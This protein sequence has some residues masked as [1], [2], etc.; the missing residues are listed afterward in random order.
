MKGK[1]RSGGDDA[2]TFLVFGDQSFDPPEQ[3][4]QVWWFG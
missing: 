3:H 4:I 1:A 2:F